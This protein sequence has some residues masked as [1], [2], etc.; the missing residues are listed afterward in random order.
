MKA[1]FMEECNVEEL[2]ENQPQNQ[3]KQRSLAQ[4]KAEFMEECNVE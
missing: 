1:E 4:M 2:A 3:P